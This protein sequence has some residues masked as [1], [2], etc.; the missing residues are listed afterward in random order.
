MSACKISK[1][2][3][4]EGVAPVFKLADLVSLYSTR[5]KE[6]GVEQHEC[7]HSTHLK[8]C[9]LAHFPD[10]A[11]HKGVTYFLHSRGSS[12]LK[13]CDQDYDDEAICLVR[14]TNITYSNYKPHSLVHLILT[15]RPSPY[16]SHRYHWWP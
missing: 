7:L 3:I 11:A 16:L 13:S 10:L 6:L 4:N 9:I 5:L 15:A 8:N 12:L 1:A 14:A 2:K